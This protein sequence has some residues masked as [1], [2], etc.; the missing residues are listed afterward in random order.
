[1]SVEIPFPITFN[2]QKHHFRFLKNEI[3]RWKIMAWEDVKQ[4][5][6]LI[7]SNLIDFYLGQL[8]V[9]QICNEC[10]SYFQA[11]NISN[12]KQFYGW[13]DGREWKKIKLSDQSEWLIRQGNSTERYIHIHPAKFSKHSIRIRAASLKTVIALRVNS[14]PIKNKANEN[15][16]NINEI[17]KV[18]LGLSPVKLLQ[19]PDSKIMRLWRL[20]ETKR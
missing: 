4:E 17:R 6:V 15:L 9:T 16:G 19:E 8:N 7:G 3:E 14:V 18:L 20:F 2:P 1:M 12:E 5:L 10:S 13:L 11:K